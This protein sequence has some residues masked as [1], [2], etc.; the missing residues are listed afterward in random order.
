MMIMV[1]YSLNKLSFDFL[2][3]FSRDSE[4]SVLNSQTLKLQKKGQDT[5]LCATW[6]SKF[7]LV[8]EMDHI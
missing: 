1:I 4:W 5:D 8:T 2:R 6:R 3:V 7:G